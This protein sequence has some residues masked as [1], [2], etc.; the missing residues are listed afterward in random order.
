[1]TVIALHHFSSGDYLRWL[2]GQLS[3]LSVER[4]NELCS[5]GADFSVIYTARSGR[6]NLF[7]GPARFVNHDCNPNCEFISL[8]GSSVSFR[9]LRSIE[10]GEELTV[11][12]GENYFGPQN[13]ECLCESCQTRPSKPVDDKTAS[14]MATESIEDETARQR[15]RHRVDDRKANL[16]FF[17]P[18]PISTSKCFHPNHQNDYPRVQC[19]YCRR[20]RMLYGT[21]WPL[22]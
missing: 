3:R 8:G 9:T 18:R 19:G 15:S 11:S 16:K 22:R 6:Y 5:K 17:S 20:H 4:S 12:Y 7:L 10:P 2:T 13:R 14:D 21:E 1:M